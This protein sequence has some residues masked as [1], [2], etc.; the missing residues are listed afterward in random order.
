ME[1]TIKK[2]KIMAS[3]TRHLEPR[4][5]AGKDPGNEKSGF[6]TSFRMTKCGSNSYYL[7]IRR[8]R[9]D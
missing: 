9:Y 7:K 4:S 2:A 1:K 8:Y 5:T 6:F 3:P